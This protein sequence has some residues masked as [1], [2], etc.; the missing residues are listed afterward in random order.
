MVK[1]LNNNLAYNPEAPAFARP[2]NLSNI[3]SHIQVAAPRSSNFS[4]NSYHVPTHS[5]VAMYSIPPP[6]SFVYTHENV[7]IVQT[8]TF[9]SYSKSYTSS[10]SSVAAGFIIK[11]ILINFKMFRFWWNCLC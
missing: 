6:N 2:A 8:T 9:S 4:L 5:K 1:K 3:Q 10:N 11:K 7:P